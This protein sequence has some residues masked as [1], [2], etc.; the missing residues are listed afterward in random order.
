MKN[1]VAIAA[2]L[3]GGLALGLLALGTG[4][5]ALLAFTNA[6]APIGTAFI[7]LLRMVIVPLVATTL[8]S[9]IAGLGDA[10][11]IGRLGAAA[12]IFFWSTTLVSIGMGMAVMWLL[13]PLAPAALPAGLATGGVEAAP[14][15]PGAAEFL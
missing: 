2:G 1:H 6:I 12:L 7:N 10:R 9:G 4:S 11:R 15:L 14:K 5:S 8:F 13:S 3:L